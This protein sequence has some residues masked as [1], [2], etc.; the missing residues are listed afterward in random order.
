VKFL[1]LRAT[2]ESIMI[3]DGGAIIYETDVVTDSPGIVMMDNPTGKYGL[4]LLST[5]HPG[6]PV[7]VIMRASGPIPVVKYNVGDVV[8]KL[9]VF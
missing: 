3:K 6:G 1:E 8:A 2:K 5:Y 7:K 9:A 4:N